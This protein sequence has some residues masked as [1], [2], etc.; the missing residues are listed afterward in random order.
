VAEGAAV[1]LA[2]DGTTQHGDWLVALGDCPN[3][4]AACRQVAAQ[5]TWELELIGI[6]LENGIALL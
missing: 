1:A 6:T 2:I 4:A 5:P 3:I